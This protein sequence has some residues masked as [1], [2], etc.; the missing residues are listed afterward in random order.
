MKKI[1]FLLTFVV[2]AMTSSATVMVCGTFAD[3][4]DGRFSSPFI[5]SGSIIWDRESR[6]LTLDNAVVEYSSDTPSDNIYPVRVTENATIVVHGNCKLTTTGHVAL[7]L[8]GYEGKSVTIQ[9]DGS[10]YISSKWIDIFLVSTRL[11][12]KDITLQVE[13]GIGNNSTGAS[14]GLTFDFVT[15]TIKGGISRIG[16][17][18]T[19]KRCAITYPEDAYIGSTDYGYFVWCGNK[20]TPDRIEIFPRAQ[21]VGDV[22]GD[23][24]VNIA[25]VNTIINV[26]ILKGDNDYLNYDNYDVNGDHDVNIADVNSIIDIILRS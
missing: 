2:I 15:A 3:E 20:Q 16:E 14:V 10:L 21:V 17:G 9:G 12:I 23:G 19:F 22:N 26:I 8:D 13:N 18:I 7:A 1:I 24:N 25:D 4:T 11:T 5:K 6:T